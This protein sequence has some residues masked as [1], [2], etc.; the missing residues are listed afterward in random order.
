MKNKIINCA[1]GC[2]NSNGEPD[3]FFVRVN[4]TQSQIVMGKHYFAA[5]DRAEK[6][7]FEPVMVFDENDPGYSYIRTEHISEDVAEITEILE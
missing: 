2:I 3:M 7:G 4:C 6:C 5:R 1:V